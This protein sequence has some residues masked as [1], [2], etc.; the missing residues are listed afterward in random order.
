MKKEKIK[1]FK[2]ASRG[3]IPLTLL[4]G[5]VIPSKKRKLLNKTLQK[6]IDEES[7]DQ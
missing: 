4:K 7:E 5:K 3:K 1:L 6:Q 2:K